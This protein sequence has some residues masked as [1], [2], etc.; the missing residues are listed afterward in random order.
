MG[1][2][3]KPSYIKW[4]FHFQ[5][6]QKKNEFLE[7]LVSFGCF[8]GLFVTFGHVTALKE[9]AKSKQKTTR[10]TTHPHEKP[11]KRS[12]HLQASAII[13]LGK[14]CYFQSVIFLLKTSYTLILSM[15]RFHCVSFCVVVYQLFLVS[16]PCES[17]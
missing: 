16:I 13:T 15:I 12:L 4:S 17:P 3:T 10:A 6:I 9:K 2:C 1:L 11:Y 8:F 7:I 14:S 5:I